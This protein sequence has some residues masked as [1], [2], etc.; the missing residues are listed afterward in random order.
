[1]GESCRVHSQLSTQFVKAATTAEAV[2][3]ECIEGVGLVPGDRIKLTT[4]SLAM[5]KQAHLAE[6]DYVASTQKLNSAVDLQ[7]QK[8]AAVFGALQDMEEKRSL[9]FRDAFMKLAVYETSFL[10]NVQYDLDNAVKSIQSKEV[11]ADLQTFIQKNQSPSTV[12]ASE[13]IKPF[14]EIATRNPVVT[15]LTMPSTAEAMAVFSKR[16]TI[17]R[18]LVHDL[19]VEVGDHDVSPDT[20]AELCHGLDNLSQSAGQGVSADPGV[21]CRAALCFALRREMGQMPLECQRGEEWDQLEVVRVQ[22]HIFGAVVSIFTAALDGCDKEN[23]AWNGRELIVLSQKICAE[24]D[25][26]VVEVLAKVY[27][28]PLWS[29]VNFW[30]MVVIVGIAEAHAMEALRRR[31]KAPSETSLMVPSPFLAKFTSYMVAFG[32]RHE[33]ACGCVLRALQRNAHLLQAAPEVYAQ[34]IAPAQDDPLL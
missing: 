9:C 18:P 29:R 28:H 21:V 14:S 27:S 33:Q 30:E 15:N 26:Q 10:H 24:V 4:H 32:I 1:M 6:R 20:L 5:C 17:L 23:D 3:K 16:L 12:L 25:G 11:H 34:T 13:T 2:A 7:E 22:P 8:M 19:L 31:G